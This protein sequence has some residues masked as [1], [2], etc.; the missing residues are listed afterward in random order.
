MSLYYDEREFLTALRST[1]DDSLEELDQVTLARLQAARKRALEHKTP[2]RGWLLPVGGITTAAAV[3]SI[4]GFLWFSMPLNE[5]VVP[6]LDDIQLLSATEDL[7]FYEE[8]DF[9]LW[10]SNET[11]AS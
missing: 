3:L 9:L 11:D 5:A 8:M 2:H 4:A 1:L 6:M 7:E 10:L